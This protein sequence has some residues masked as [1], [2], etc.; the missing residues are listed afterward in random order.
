MQST[1]PS[2]LSVR[3][4][5][6]SIQEARVQEV[7]IATLYI[8]S[9]S[10][11]I[12]RS[13]LASNATRHS[14]SISRPRGKDKHKVMIQR[15]SKLN[16][17]QVEED[18][19]TV[20]DEENEVNMEIPIGT[21]ALISMDRA[22]DVIE[23]EEDQID[24]TTQGEIIIEMIETE[25][26]GEEIEMREIGAREVLILVIGRTDIGTEVRTATETKTVIETV[27]MVQISTERV[28][29]ETADPDQET[30]HALEVLVRRAHQ[31]VDKPL[32]KD[33]P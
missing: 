27:I 24:E 32:R 8:Q 9:M 5:V 25:T 33:E 2:L 14:R 13:S 12:L 30:D 21:V 28:T 20:K 1:A 4:A 23:I 26:T 3:R 22:Q 6:G 7:V 18:Q 11:L 15:V 31:L 16:Q 19:G 29:P 10:Q 17:D